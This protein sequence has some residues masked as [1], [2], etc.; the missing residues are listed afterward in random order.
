N[1][2]GSWNASRNDGTRDATQYFMAESKNRGASFAAAFAVA[3]Q[4]TDETLT[5]ADF[6]NQYGD[7]ED[8]ARVGGTVRPIWTDR[9]ASVAAVAGLDE[10]IFTEAIK[11]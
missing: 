9:R 5:G 10:E 2:I 11:E 7:Y 6:G 3:T 4:P 1:V 8:R